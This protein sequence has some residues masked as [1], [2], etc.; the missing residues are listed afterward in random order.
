MIA[1]A[2]CENCAPI[3]DPGALVFELGLIG[4]DANES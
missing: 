1:N 4:T 3:K 2:C